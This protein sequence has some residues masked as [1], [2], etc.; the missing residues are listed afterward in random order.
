MTKAQGYMVMSL[1]AGLA[2]QASN[3]I[4]SVTA[5]A[6]GALAWAVMS[7]REALNEP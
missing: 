4:V 3:N 1:L 5:F 2:M 7:L 6:F